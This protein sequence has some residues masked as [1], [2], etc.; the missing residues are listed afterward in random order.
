MTPIDISVFNGGWNL[1]LWAAQSQGFFST[2]ELTITL[3]YTPGSTELIQ[4]FH[5]GVYPIVFCSADN[6]VAYQGNRAEIPITG[7]PDARIFLSVDFGFLYPVLGP[8]IGSLSELKGKTIGVDKKD[9]GFAFVLYE[10]LK[11]A[12]I[13]LK[14]VTICEMGSTQNRLSAL[15]EQKCHATLLRPP[16]QSIAALQ[17]CT[18]VRETG[19][20]PRGYQGTVGVVKAS[21]AI[22]HAEVLN[23]FSSA[24]QEGLAWVY[25]NPEES[26]AILTNMCGD[27]SSELANTTYRELTDDKTG[28]DREITP[29]ELRLEEV[30]RLRNAHSLDLT[31]LRPLKIDLKSI[32]QDLR[33]Q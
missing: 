21:W 22:E 31:G 3:Q 28:F 30:L 6:V 25:E 9:T 2:H 29:E 12:G 24:Y 15:I 10:V 20:D 32:L 4:G 5:D 19:F 16:Y 27:L 1:P 18:L 33:R 14:D 7:I 17:G 26:I 8:D 13:S 11:K 23:R